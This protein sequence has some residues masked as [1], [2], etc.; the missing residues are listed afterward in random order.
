MSKYYGDLNR[1]DVSHFSYHLNLVNCN[2]KPTYGDAE[3]DFILLSKLV[4]EYYDIDTAAPLDISCFLLANPK[5]PLSVNCNAG[6]FRKVFDLR[7]SNVQRF[8]TNLGHVDWNYVFDTQLSLDEK[9]TE[10]H[11]IL[12]T[13]IQESIPVSFVKF[14][15]TNK[16]W[17]TPK[18]K[19]P[20]QFKMDSSPKW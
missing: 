16:P 6:V 15:P 14:T 18:V 1:F 8:L 10:F 3:L 20:Y 13:T 7:K 5:R 17:I 11:R 2:N 12:S 9:C 4:A 19:I